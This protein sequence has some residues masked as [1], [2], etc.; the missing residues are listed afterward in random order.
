MPLETS[1]V[2]FILLTD[3]TH[4]NISLAQ[5]GLSYPHFGQNKG[6]FD[7]RMTIF[8]SFFRIRLVNN[9]LI[10]EITGKLEI[11]S[12]KGFIAYQHLTMFFDHFFA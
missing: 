6:F 4:G 3:V 12:I 5:K 9:Q 1:L 11:L 8:Y 2:I 10:S 7:Y